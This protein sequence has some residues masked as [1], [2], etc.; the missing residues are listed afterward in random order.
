MS[1]ETLLTEIILSIAGVVVSALGALVSY[2]ISKKIKDDKIKTI[3]NELNE[4]VKKATLEVYQTYVEELK[5]KNMFD[6]EAQKKALS[7]ALDIIKTN[8]STDVLKWLETNFKD[9]EKYLKG[10]VEAQ[11]ALLKK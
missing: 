5:E 6:V 3:V 2:W 11:I 7:R 1:W 10:L 9:V 8:L 4:V